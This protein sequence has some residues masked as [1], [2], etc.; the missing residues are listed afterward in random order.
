M[1]SCLLLQFRQLNTMYTFNQNQT[2]LL[3]QTQNYIEHK[4]VTSQQKRHREGDGKQADDI[5]AHSAHLLS[6]YLWDNTQL[7]SSK[8]LCALQ[9]SQVPICDEYS[10][11]NI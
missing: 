5:N 3:T 8:F 6:I 9:K 2:N 10:N 4:N 7:N 1:V 11:R